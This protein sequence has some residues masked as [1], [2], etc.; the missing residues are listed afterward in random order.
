MSGGQSVFEA[1]VFAEQKLLPPTSP[2]VG[3]KNILL[4]LQKN[5]F[6]LKLMA[7]SQLMQLSSK[8]R[9]RGFS[10]ANQ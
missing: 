4:T 3:K 1:K 10:P 2:R 5:I 9:R 7:L 8:S 6:G